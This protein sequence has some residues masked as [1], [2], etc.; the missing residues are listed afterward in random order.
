MP[1]RRARGERVR[2]GVA[3]RPASPD[4][5]HPDPTTELRLTT[6]Q[7]TRG[8]NF[9]SRRPVTRMDLRV[10]AYDDISSA[11]VS[12]L[13]EALLRAMP[14]LVEHR[15]S[16][17]DRGGF[18]RRLRLG[19]YAPHIVEHVAL[20]LQ[21]MIGHD[22]G[23]GR[24]RGGDEP[25]A[26]TLVF[27]HRHDAVGRR[28]AALALETVQRAFAGTL[29]DV[30]AAVAE[31]ALI[32]TGP[33]VPPIQH[34]V[35]AGITG[36]AGRRETQSL[37]DARLAARRGSEE[38]DGE[39]LVID[40]S[41]AFLLHSGLPYARS[42]LA[43]ILDARLTDVPPRYTAPERARRLVTVL[44]DGLAD[45]GSLVCP[46]TDWEIQDYARDRGYR[47]AVF[48]PDGRVSARD[49]RV[50]CGVAIVRDGRLVVECG[51]VTWDAGPADPSLA[52]VPQV[53]AAMAA[54]LASEP[55]NDHPVH[56]R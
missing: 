15:C 45:G 35:L 30:R 36:G 38:Q 40:V 49:L 9:W 21:A 13:T 22:V 34:R 4:P 31:L 55:R 56:A 26:Y 51:D 28:A 37:L 24:T 17:G 10:G 50:A 5:G 6:L 23:F 29:T 43:V 46:A 14:G 54:A 47:V 11:D 52:P 53:A 2:D 3:P 42:E 39:R 12:G 44:V 1:R 16:I 18:V 8:A 33:D 48:S 20:E 41:P 7:T 27:E 32:A 19:T 25:H